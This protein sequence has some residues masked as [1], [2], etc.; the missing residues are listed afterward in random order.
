LVGPHPTEA[1]MKHRQS[2]NGATIRSTAMQ[3]HFQIHLREHL[4]P[5]WSTWF[6]GMRIEH[7]P[8][9]TTSLIGPVADQAALYGL[10]GKARDLGLCLLAVIPIARDGPAPQ[11]R[12][13]SAHAPAEG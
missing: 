1:A 2:S 12:P 3:T 8:D 4:D 5:G 9:G 10:I 7:H 11:L 13:A 6:D